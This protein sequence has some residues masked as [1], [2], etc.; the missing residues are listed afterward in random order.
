MSETEEYLNLIKNCL[1]KN[2]IDF[3]DAEFIAD[4][5][6][7]MVKLL[8]FSL[9]IVCA[10]MY[11]IQIRITEERKKTYFQSIRDNDPKEEDTL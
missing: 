2:S 10:K 7:H 9:K 4:A 6:K 8:D 5:I 11:S 1:D 3:N